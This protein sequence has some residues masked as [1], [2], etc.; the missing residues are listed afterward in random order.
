[1]EINDL[2]RDSVLIY[3]QESK[4]IFNIDVTKNFEKIQKYFK[5]LDENPEEKMF[6]LDKIF[7]N[8][9]KIKIINTRRLMNKKIKK[10][11]L[12]Y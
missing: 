5:K 7:N 10:K 8:L 1:M 6:K 11:Y 2:V 3:I 12:I 4:N 9:K